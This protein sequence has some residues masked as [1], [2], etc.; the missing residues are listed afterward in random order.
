MEKINEKDD[1]DCWLNY[2]EDMNIVKKFITHIYNNT[3]DVTSF[4]Y[5]FSTNFDTFFY[6]SSSQMEK[7]STEGDAF[8]KGTTTDEL[9]EN[10][11]L[12]INIYFSWLT[13][14]HQIFKDM[15]NALGDILTDYC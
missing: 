4:R 1:M 10:V 2:I 6:N 7:E 9:S 12:D 8:K 14:I 13:K 11:T 15:Y 5:P 3:K